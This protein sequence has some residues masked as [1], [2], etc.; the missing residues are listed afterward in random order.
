MD[1]VND[2]NCFGCGQDNAGGL[3]L[4]FRREQGKASS[5]FVLDKTFQ[6]YKNMLHGGVI[7]TIMDEAMVHA[8]IFE[9]LFPVTAE[10][11]VR[12]IKPVFVEQHLTV[13]GWLAEKGS[14]KIEARAQL[15]DKQSGAICAESSA[16]L[17]LP[18][19][20]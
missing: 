1:I 18:K 11:T 12:Y 3:K 7:A 20:L 5:E 19:Q 16:K 6:G 17:I 10:M 2:R 9:D 15:I 8:A 13:E 4:I 14:R